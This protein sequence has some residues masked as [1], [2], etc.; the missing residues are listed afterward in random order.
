MSDKSA[1]LPLLFPFRQK[2]SPEIFSSAVSSP[3]HTFSPTQPP[4][5]SSS[6]LP[7]ISLLVSPSFTAQTASVPVILCH[8]YTF[9]FLIYTY[10]AYEVSFVWFSLCMFVS[11]ELAPCCPFPTRFR[12]VIPLFKRSVF[13]SN[14]SVI[15]SVHS[16]VPK[17][18][19]DVKAILTVLFLLFSSS[20]YLFSCQNSP[21]AP[22]ILYSPC[23][24][25]LLF[26]QH[27]VL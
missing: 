4:S 9:C 20:V 8:V 26:P 18:I 23:H 1:N 11:R 5:Y 2:R 22:P 25:L 21:S 17:G 19:A 3:G 10:V 12:F 16:S 15:F 7:S 24:L 14:T 6:A 27:F 13:L